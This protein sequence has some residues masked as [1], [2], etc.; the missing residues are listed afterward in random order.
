MFMAG[1]DQATLRSRFIFREL[2]KEI[3]PHMT[4]DGTRKF[5]TSGCEALV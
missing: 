4:A 3:F 1:G 2:E 5:S